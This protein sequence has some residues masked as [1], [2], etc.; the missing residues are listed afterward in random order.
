MRLFLVGLIAAAAPFLPLLVSACNDSSEY[1]VAPPR[2][3]ITKVE[4]PTGNAVLCD[5]A[6]T[7]GVCPLAIKVTFRLPEDQLVTKAIVR[8]QGDGNDIGVDRAY[9]LP[10]TYGKGDADVPLAFEALLPATILRRSALFTYSIRL[11]TGRGEE[12]AA[13]TLTVSNQ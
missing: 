1:E 9:A 5:P 3:Q 10:V 2:P 6:T 12:S 11:V 4:G 13:T 8:F 7:G